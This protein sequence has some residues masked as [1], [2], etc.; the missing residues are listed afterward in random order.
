VQ[1][2]AVFKVG[3]QVGAVKLG[4]SSRGA[5]WGVVDFVVSIL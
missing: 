3:F 4:C 2:K 5:G 1:V